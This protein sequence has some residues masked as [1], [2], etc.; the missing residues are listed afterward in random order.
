M[1]KFT[2]LLMA[3]LFCG[4][5]T[6]SA[7]DDEVKVTPAFND[8][9]EPTFQFSNDCKYYA[10]FLDE[11]TKAANL[12]DDQYVYIGAEEEA[13]RH[14][15]VWNETYSFNTPS[16]TNSMNIPEGYL[17]LKVGNAGWSGLGYAND[18]PI[19]LSGIT[20]D[21]TL[22]FAIKSTSAESFDFKFGDGTYD[23]KG[24]KSNNPADIVLGSKAFDKSE[25][26]ADFTRDGEWYNIDIPVS[27]LEDNFGL[28]LSKNKFFKGNILSILAGGVAGTVVDFDAV[29]FYGPKNTSSTGISE[30]AAGTQSGKKEYFTADGKQVSEAQAK[31]AKGLYIVKQNGSAKKIVF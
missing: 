26:V 23:E 17:S 10:I 25:P 6:A 12:S 1:K 8:D 15:Y 30:V 5:F 14:L 29:F 20:S 27:Y 11:E 31:A 2:Y 18:N 3:A 28:S 13:G 16:G 4:S 9:F 7:Q 21:Y 19:D 24:E 22:H